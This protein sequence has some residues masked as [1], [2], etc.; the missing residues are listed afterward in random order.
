MKSVLENRFVC[1]T[2][3]KFGHAVV[4]SHLGYWLI[5]SCKKLII[6]EQKGME[7]M[8]NFFLFLPHCIGSRGAGRG[9]G[10]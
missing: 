3:L 5:P 1:S 2:L 6:I 8:Y 4:I 7:S 10:P 9:E